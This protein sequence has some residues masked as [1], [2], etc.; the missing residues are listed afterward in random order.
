[1]LRSDS[2]ATSLRPDVVIKLGGLHASKVLA[3]RLREWSGSG[4]RQVI[5]EGRWRWPDPDRD[6]T[7]VIRSEPSAWCE[8]ICKSVE[9]LPRERDGAWLRR[10][11]LAES[12]AQSAIDTWCT[13]H[14]E[15]TEPGLARC[16]LGA[17]APSTALVV[18]SSMP[19][20]DLEWYAP[21]TDNPPRVLAN[22]GANGIDGVVSTAL[23]VAS[24]GTSPVAALVGD[25]A[26]FHD[27]SA[28][29]GTLPRDPGLTV[30]VVD[31][32]GGGIFSF[33]PQHDSLDR[34]TFERLLATPQSVEVGRVARGL[35]LEVAE[36]STIDDTVD[37]IRSATSSGATSVVHVKVPGRE[38]NVGHH[39]SLNSLISERVISALARMD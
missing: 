23:G 13:V 1:V 29:V 36:V 10:W 16:L 6:A 39:E 7:K 9:E 31:N 34:Q 21:A 26:F 37:A 35:G 5:V 22:R 33:L 25:L 32:D 19:I 8:D 2:V 12:E 4:T 18:S 11:E 28:W 20:R 3:G 24:S 15:A 38:S 17:V 14:R 30:V 27:L